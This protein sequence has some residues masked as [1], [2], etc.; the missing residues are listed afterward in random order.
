MMKKRSIFKALALGA[1]LALPA[2]AELRISEIQAENLNTLDDDELNSPDWVE[3]ENTGDSAEDL[4]GYFLTDSRGKLDKWEFPSGIKVPAGKQIVIFASEKD[5]HTPLTIFQQS[6]PIKPTHTNFKLGVKGEYLALVAPDGETVVYDFPDEYPRMVGNVSYGID[7]NGDMGYFKEPTPGE[8]NGVSVPLGPFIDDVVNVTGPPD[9]ATTDTM[10]ITAEV[11]ENEFPVS[12]V[13]LYHRFMFKSESRTTMRDD[14]EVPDETAGDGVYTAEISL[15]SVFGA[16]VASG[17]MI[18]WRVE[19]EDDQGN[20]QRL[21]LFHDPGNADEYFGTVAQ[22][23]SLATSNLPILHWFI[24]SPNSANTD[25]G[26]KAS[27]SYLGE[28]YDN[29]HVDIHGQSTRGGAFPK[30]SWDF[31]F[32]TGHGFKYS[33]DG[34]RVKD[35][36]ML[37]NWADK[38]KVRNSTSYE[39]YRLGGVRGHF[40]FPVRVQQ[41]GDFYGTWDIVEDGDEDFTKRVGLSEDGALYKMYNRLDSIG[42]QDPFSSNGGEKK[43]RRFEGKDDLQD[44]IDGVSDGTT[45]DKLDYIYDNV[46]IASQINYL[47]MNTVINNTDFGHKNYYVYRD[48]EG[49]GEW[50]ELP[51]D[52]DLSLGRLWTQGAN[53]FYDPI[54][55]TVRAV[56]NVS[57]NRLATIFNSNSD[58][59]AML[60]RR[61]RTLYDEF[62][63]PPG[64]APKSDFFNEQFDRLLE[65]FDPEGIESDFDLEYEKWGSWGNDDT[66]REAVARIRDEYIP[67]RIDYIYGLSKLPREQK[68]YSDFNLKIDK[69][70]FR[71]ASGNQLEEYLVIKNETGELV[72]LSNFEIKGAIEHTIKP[73]T[74]LDSGTVFSPAKGNLYI[75]RDARAFRARAESPTGGERNFVQGNY[76]GQLSARGETI[77]I[78][79]PEG[80]LVV[81]TAYEGDPSMAQAGLR[82]SEIMY[83]PAAPEEGS[84]YKSKDFEYV[85]LTNTG[86]S[87]IDLSGIAFTEGVRFAFADG[88]MLEP[89]V[90]ALL[91]SNQV[92]FESRYGAGLNILG[93]FEG[94]F[95]NSG[96]RVVLRDAMDENVLAFSIDE[97]WQP[98]ADKEGYSLEV[99]NAAQE[100]ALWDVTE[101]W[102]ASAEVGGTPGS[103]EGSVI[104]NPPTGMTYASW[105]KAQF[106]EAEA[107]ND[108]ISG[109]ESDANGDGVVNLLAYAFNVSPYESAVY[110]EITI[111]AEALSV[112]FTQH[113]DVDDLT[114]AVQ[115][116]E[117]LQAWSTAGEM[118]GEPTPG[119]GNTQ[120]VTIKAPQ[121]DGRANYVRLMVELTP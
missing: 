88:T 50:T 55:T 26:T 44:L 20:A 90:V 59:S 115:V 77:Q 103:H 114:Y 33:E 96:D 106:S 110:P 23:A 102:K 28:F 79:D 2:K 104:V 40:A 13:S 43:T 72:D 42:S 70:D 16:Q 100:V 1:L 14:G 86:D 117:D 74:I 6:D 4:R 109:P 116:S 25:S 83:N 18:R 120:R 61:I 94:N 113:T 112:S 111:N 99:A 30:K 22:D 47:A 121:P 68:P 80:N 29:I 84:P 76:S 41:N 65:T 19:A 34:E 46:D 60:H 78:F 54:Q 67:G 75:V 17:E 49:T 85:E 8:A 36:N 56:N 57:G 10:V 91:V 3:I 48:T 69:V 32:N 98:Q 58:F 5:Q 101:G 21:P 63:G 97:E 39:L 87:A 38:S 45:S 105:R 66:M 92:A 82:I 31:D 52:V 119:A 7:S 11:L 118:D 62:Y 15:K 51:W 12:R 37:T 108:D 27:V 89:G 81:E 9:V 35:I 71:P 64:G 95:S 93:E 24:E 73:G 53:Y 107:S